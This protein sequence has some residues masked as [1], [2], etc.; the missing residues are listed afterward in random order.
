MQSQQNRAVGGASS[1]GLLGGTIGLLL[2]GFIG[3]VTLQTR[4]SGSEFFDQLF[5]PLDACFGFFGM[6]AGAAI[7][8]V[9]GA[10]G[11]STFGAGWATRARRHA[12]GDSPKSESQT[13]APATPPDE[14]AET[15]L[16]RFREWLA[17]S[18]RENQKD[19]ES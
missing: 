9:I 12:S 17:E 10:V 11:G 2:G 18:E 16:A 5:A 7:G 1:G 13:T 3:W 8:G 19:S 6:L 14:S 15:Q 4:S